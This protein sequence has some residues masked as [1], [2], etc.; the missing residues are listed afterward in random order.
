MSQRGGQ[1]P[2]GRVQVRGFV[3]LPD[4][5][6]VEE[7]PGMTRR[8]RLLLTAAS[9]AIA[10]TSLVVLVANTSPITALAGI[11]ITYGA[12]GLG[13]RRIKLAPRES[14]FDFEPATS[15]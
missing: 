2:P 13:L 5:T 12:L 15:G 1:N 8:S 3:G 9:S 6:R 4:G 14:R 11:A 10:A 7:C